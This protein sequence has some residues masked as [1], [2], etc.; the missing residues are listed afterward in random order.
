MIGEQATKKCVS[1]YFVVNLTLERM[2]V[3]IYIHALSFHWKIY[4]KLF[5]EQDESTEMHLG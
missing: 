2:S 4:R 3:A 1:Y 5:I